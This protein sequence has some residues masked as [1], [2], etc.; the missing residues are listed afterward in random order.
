MNA[1]IEPAAPAPTSSKRRKVL[2]LIALIFIVLGALWAAYWILVL[3]KREQTD[4][5]YVNGNKV[6]ISAQVSGTVVAVLT[7]DT[8][9]VTAGQVLARLDPTDAETSLNRAASALGQS[10]RQ[11]R[12]E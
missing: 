1:T 6:V 2:L 12:V 5:A 4:D 7:D 10:V 8:Q 9:L 3:S 11:V